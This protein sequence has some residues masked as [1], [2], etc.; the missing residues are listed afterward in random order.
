[1]RQNEPRPQCVR[2]K[3]SRRPEKYEQCRPT[4]CVRRS[5]TEYSPEGSAETRPR[6]SRGARRREYTLPSPSRIVVMGAVVS[7]ATGG[8][9]D[10][11]GA[12]ASHS[13]HTDSVAERM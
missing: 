11:P 9:E 1:M 13:T 12:V 5:L 2:T 6:S 3:R 7:R 10:A 8:F 4:R